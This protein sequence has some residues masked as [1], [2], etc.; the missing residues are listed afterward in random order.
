MKK[1]F[2]FFSL[3]VLT[4]IVVS[5]LACSAIMTKNPL[6][7]DLAHCNEAPGKEFLF[8]TDAMGRDI[9]SMIW[10]GGRISLTIGFLATLFST[11][12][13]VF[14]GSVSGC[15]PARI[16]GVLMGMTELFLSVPGLLLTVFLQA[17]FVRTN[18]YSLSVVIGLTGWM[19]M[20]K[21]VRTE[22]MQLKNMDY[23]LAARCLGGGFFHV[24]IRHLAPNF[25]PSVLFMA[26]M[27]VRNAIVAEATLSFMGLGLPV[28]EV[29][30]GSMLSLSENVFLSGSWW[31]IL[32]PGA[33]LTGTLLCLTNLGNYM[34]GSANKRHSNLGRQGILKIKKR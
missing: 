3:S 1:R 34:R 33:F 9:F 6:Y 30:W 14:A 12:L 13:A 10:Y 22:V 31:I 18:V 29:S 8:G 20:A 28:E 15:A 11:I 7:M 5:C 4:A 23:V 16:D 25:F 24:L 17:V 32:I 19:S 26:V 2:P 27:N 21:V